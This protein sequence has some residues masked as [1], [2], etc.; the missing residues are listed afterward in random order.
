M[1]KAVDLG[2]GRHVAT[3]SNMADLSTMLELVYVS[4]ILFDAGITFAKLSALCFYLRVFTVRSRRFKWCFG[5]TVFLVVAYA[6]YKLPLQI[7]EC[8]PPRKFWEPQTP[9]HCT[10][11]YTNLGHLLCGLIWDA[12]TDFM[13]LILPMPI[14]STL[15]MPRGRR[16]SIIITFF[17]G[18]L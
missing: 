13:I 9:G 1:I 17:C 11:G 6:A 12:V 14:I 3:I 2:M 10:N 4:E 15:H 7:A 8:I 5:V 18:Y 16:A